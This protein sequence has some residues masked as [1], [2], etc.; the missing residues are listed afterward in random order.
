ME[1]MHHCMMV[2]ATMNA[3]TNPLHLSGRPGA[4]CAW[5]DKVP[6]W[7]VPEADKSVR[8]VALESRLAG[9]RNPPTKTKMEIHQ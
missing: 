2:A 3:R 6:D 7:D 1:S 9:V 5:G 8:S 4:Y